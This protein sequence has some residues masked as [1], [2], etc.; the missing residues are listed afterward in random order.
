MPTTLQGSLFAAGSHTSWKAA[1]NSDKRRG[2]KMRA[3][4]CLLGSR[5]PVTD[6]EAAHALTLPL[7]SICSIRNGA[8]TAQLVTKGFTTRTGP[9]GHQNAT[10]DLTREGQAA[11]RVMRG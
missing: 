5:G 8:I 10:W 6:H 9:H 1:V 4:L 7:S 11:V 3:Y 2:A